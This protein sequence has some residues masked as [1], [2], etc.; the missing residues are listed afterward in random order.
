MKHLWTRMAATPSEV[1]AALDTSWRLTAEELNEVLEQMTHRGFL[2]RQKVSPSNEFS[3]FGIAQI[4]MSSKNR[5]NKVY[6]YWPVVQKNKLVTYLDAQ[7]YLAYS[8]ARKHASNG[9]SNDYYTFF[10]EKLMRLLE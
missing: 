9:V 2:A 3:L 10:E 1:Y 7:R 6:V 5:K 4:E 8:S